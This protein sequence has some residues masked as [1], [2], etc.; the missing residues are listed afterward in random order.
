MTTDQTLQTSAPST[1]LSSQIAQFAIDTR[2]NGLPQ[3]VADI[4][5]QLL[6]DIAGLCIAAR[7]TDYVAATAKATETGGHCTALGQADGRDMYGAAL[8]NGTAAH[9]EDFDDTFEGGPIHSSAVIWPAVLAVGERYGLTGPQVMAGMAIG[10][11]LMCRLA[12]VAPKAIHKA[13]FHP[14]AVIGTLGASAA[15]ATALGLNRGQFVNAL[16]IAGSM[17]SGIIEYLADG[18][19][20]KRMHAGWAAQ[21]GIRAAVMARH[22]FVGPKTVLEGTHGFFSGFAPSRTPDFSK[23]TDG[24]GSH[25]HMTSIAFKPYACGTMTQPYV[26]C[27]IEL[28]KCGISAVDIQSIVCKVGEGTVHRLWEPLENKQAPKTAYAGKFST[29]YC[30]AV[31][32]LDR[33]AGLE[34]FTEQRIAD[35]DVTA[36]AKKVS[37]EVDPDN[38]YPDRFTGHLRVTLTNGDVLE[39]TRENMRGGAHEPLSNEEIEAKYCQNVLFGGWSQESANQLHQFCNDISSAT[40]LS[41]LSRF[42]DQLP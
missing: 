27:A 20:T 10:T 7:G 11:E 1:D 4:G 32:F 2:G 26:D 28:A 39:L 31:G 6:L 9:G 22:G 38:P 23:L 24:L 8:I 25:W 30:I 41:T 35:L 40:A 3:A 14:T 18:S 21:S 15:A 16:G 33:A 19:W 37:Y 5:S 29:P 36:L 34:Q 12:M 42:R 17:A 13:G